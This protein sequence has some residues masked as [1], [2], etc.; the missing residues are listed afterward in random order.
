MVVKVIRDSSLR[1][2]LAPDM[3]ARL[4]R[5]ADTF[6]APPSTL[7]AV[8]LG[9]VVSRKEKEMGMVDQIASVVGASAQDVLR[10]MQ[11]SLLSAQHSPDE[12]GVPCEALGGGAP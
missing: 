11:L 6:G 1:L 12:Q 4:D 7:A 9:E 2:K 8:W 3:K 10:D 5:L